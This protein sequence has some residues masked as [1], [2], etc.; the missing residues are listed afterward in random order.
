MGQIEKS[1]SIKSA[2]EDT[3]IFDSKREVIF[4]QKPHQT[5]VFNRQKIESN[6]KFNGPAIIQESTATTIIPPNYSIVKDDFG[7]IIITKEE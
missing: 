6:N 7:N 5:N 2:S 3:E 4:N 1:G